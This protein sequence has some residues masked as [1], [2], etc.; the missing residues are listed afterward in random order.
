MRGCHE[1]TFQPYIVSAR[2]C[3][4]GEVNGIIIY[5]TVGDQSEYSLPSKGSDVDLGD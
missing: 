1:F 5:K 4:N 3:K 2:A